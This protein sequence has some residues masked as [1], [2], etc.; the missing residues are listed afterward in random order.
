MKKRDEKKTVDTMQTPYARVCVRVNCYCFCFRHWKDGICLCVCA[1]AQRIYLSIWHVCA[2]MDIWMV[3]VYVRIK[4]E[5]KGLTYPISLQV[6]YCWCLIVVSYIEE[7]DICKQDNLSAVAIV[8]FSSLSVFLSLSYLLLFVWDRWWASPSFSFS[9]VSIITRGI[10][11][12]RLKT[13]FLYFSFCLYSIRCCRSLA[14]CL[15][16]NHR[17]SI[18]M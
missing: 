13:N 8:A 10:F 16:E 1:T 17:A 7:I 18:N 3:L 14:L 11:H 6:N 2:C 5:K 4:K 15:C 12:A 9:L